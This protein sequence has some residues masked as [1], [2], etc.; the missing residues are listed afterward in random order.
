MNKPTTNKIVIYTTAFI[1]AFLLI[2]E[3]AETK[4]AIS[5]FGISPSFTMLILGFLLVF[6]APLLIGFIFAVPFFLF[7]KK[8]NLRYILYFALSFL[9]LLFIYYLLEQYTAIFKDFYGFTDFSEF[10]YYFHYDKGPLLWTTI[11]QF[12][13]ETL[14]FFLFVTKS[15]ISL[16]AGF[17]FH[18]CLEIQRVKNIK[19]E[20]KN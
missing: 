2:E 9:I 14:T 13:V 17:I 11:V 10:M 12:C 20:Q 16:T 4:S 1:L 7:M 6:V 19:G 3:I 5:N 15:W 8:E 18:L